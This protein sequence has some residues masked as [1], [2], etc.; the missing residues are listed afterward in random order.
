MNCGEEPPNTTTSPAARALPFLLPSARHDACLAATA[1]RASSLVKE[2]TPPRALKHE[3]AVQD[4]P[5]ISTRITLIQKIP[6]GVRGGLRR[7]RIMSVPREAASPRRRRRRWTTSIWSR[8]PTTA[9]G[10]GPGG[11]TTRGSTAPPPAGRRFYVVVKRPNAASPAECP[12]RWRTRGSASQRRLA[13]SPPSASTPTPTPSAN[14]TPSRTT[15]RVSNTRGA[16]STVHTPP[17]LALRRKR[18]EHAS[19]GQ[20]IWRSPFVIM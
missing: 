20:S 1:C 4:D 10:S 14:S 18:R 15:R 16:D 17:F 6:A 12:A 8:S 19:I 7:R 9:A 5:I 13:P 3:G 2:P 11:G